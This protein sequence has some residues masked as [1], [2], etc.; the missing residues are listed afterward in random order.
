[1]YASEAERRESHQ[2]QKVKIDLTDNEA[3]K[4]GNFR[5][6]NNDGESNREEDNQ[7]D[8][9]REENN[10][11]DDEAKEEKSPS[12]DKKKVRK[13]LGDIHLK[14]KHLK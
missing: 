5:V 6:E 4:Q 3:D 14:Q 9:D 10:D 11:G 13:V 12:K 8:G 1:M 7:G 2:N